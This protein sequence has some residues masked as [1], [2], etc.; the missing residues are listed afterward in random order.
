MQ[1]TYER[2][3]ERDNEDFKDRKTLTPEAEAKGKRFICDLSV[4]GVLHHSIFCIKIRSLPDLT[5]SWSKIMIFSDM[6]Q[7]AFKKDSVN[8][9][10]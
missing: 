2:G 10:I 8:F 9:G 7:I 3:P 4:T 6:V 1:N 5:I